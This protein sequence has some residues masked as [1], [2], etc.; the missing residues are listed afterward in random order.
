[1]TLTDNEGFVILAAMVTA[2]IVGFA[3]RRAALSLLPL[4][5][6]GGFLA[7]TLSSDDAYSRIPEDVQITVVYALALST[8]LILAGVVIRRIVDAERVR[9][10]SRGTI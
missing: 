3:T 6:A 9:R 2:L 1:M 5:G 4:L 7:Y 8:A 10:R